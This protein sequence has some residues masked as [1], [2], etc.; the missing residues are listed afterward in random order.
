MITKRIYEIAKELNLQ[1]KEVQ[2]KFQAIGVQLKSASSSVTIDQYELF[3][4]RYAKLFQNQPPPAKAA[5]PAAGQ[6]KTFTVVRQAEDQLSQIREQ[7]TERRVSG[8]VIR[9]RSKI[10][11]SPAPPPAPV[12]S[13][14]AAPA[15]AAPG[16]TAARPAAPAESAPEAAPSTAPTEGEEAPRLKIV[17]PVKPDFVPR[18]ERPAPAPAK[19]APTGPEAAVPGEP[20]KAPIRGKERKPEEDRIDRKGQKVEKRVLVQ[21]QVEDDWRETKRMI[22]KRKEFEEAGFLAPEER[23]AEGPTRRPRKKPRAT[24]VRGKGQ[25]AVAGPAK[26][27]PIRLEQSITLSEMASAMG[28][29]SAELI[30]KLLGMDIMATANQAIDADTAAVLAAEYGYEIERVG[31]NEDSALRQGEDAPESLQSRPPVVTI[32]GHVDHGKTSLLD[33]IRS[34]RVAEGEAGGITQHIGAYHVDTPKG[35]LTFLDTPGHEAFTAMRARGAQAT[36]VVILVVAADD[37]VMPQTLEAVN[38]ARAAEVPIVVAVN[39]ID[40]P[41]AKPD[42]I[43]TQLSEHQLAPEEWGGETLYANVSAKT[44]EGIPDLLEKVA[45]QAEMLEL[46]ANPRKPARGLVIEAR[47]EKGRGPVA[48]VLVQEGTLHLGDAIV[49]G[50][51]FGRARALR[52]DLGKQIES[53]GPGLPVEIFGLSG[54]PSAGD[55]F[56]AAEDEKLARQVAEKRAHKAREADLAASKKV[57]LEQLFEQIGKGETKELAAV[58]KTDVQGSTEAILKALEAIPSERCRVKVIHQGVGGI[59]ESDVQLAAASRAIVL[60]FNVRPDRMAQELAEQQHVDVRTY[61]II[62]ELVDAVRQ[63]MEG[64]LEP[65]TKEKVIGHVEIRQIFSVAKAGKVAGCYVQ[66]GK[67]TRSSRVR[68]L[69]DGKVVYTGQLSSLKRFKDDAR[70][71]LAGLECGLSVADFNDYKTGDILEVF[72]VEKVAARLDSPAPAPAGRPDQPAA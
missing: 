64:L 27:K 25:L 53:V 56:D 66:D 54:V 38:H 50:Q 40:K 35:P 45:L 57:T 28:V 36:D 62:Y 51:H 1:S 14:P 43:K 3:R 61:S 24:I 65:E 59:T 72:E 20:G 26:K 5:Q 68:L 34:A 44:G 52:D 46:K 58:L 2:E 12:A 41:G 8:S 23:A 32:M 63:A 19:A 10:D 15:P 9:R 33:K 47:L 31:L 71:V 48:T 42:Q 16:P 49:A 13:A 70:E 60:G 67:V 30:K 39:K 69:R 21:K 7:V 17:Q 11:D 18:I 29:K 4:Q 6:E 55:P 22:T 37:G